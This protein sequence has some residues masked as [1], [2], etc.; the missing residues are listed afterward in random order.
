MKKAFRRMLCFILLTICLMT[1]VTAAVITPVEP[2]WDNVNQVICEIYF[3]GTKGTVICDI[4]AV[5]GTTSIKGTLT[6]YEDD[7]EI[8][9]WDIDTKTSSAT[10]SDT[11]T[12][13]KGCTYKLV[14]D[15]DVTLKG[16]VEPITHTSTK[17][18]S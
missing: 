12:G 11:F 1:N 6:L 15:V 13:T 2:N 7:V 8:D 3:S 18:C 9:S 17:K 16:I 14:L 4:S 5:S 10:V